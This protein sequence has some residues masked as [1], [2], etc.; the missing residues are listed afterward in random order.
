M[1]LLRLLFFLVPALIHAIENDYRK[2]RLK[3]VQAQEALSA[4][5]VTS[6]SSHRVLLDSRTDSMSSQ[7][8]SI[9]I[10]SLI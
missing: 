1:L 5:S 8:L 6:T 9:R 2:G 4:V 7:Y 3:R 10:P